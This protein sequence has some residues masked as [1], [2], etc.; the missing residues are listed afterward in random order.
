MSDDSF[1]KL[2]LSG[3][4]SV[5]QKTGIYECGS[6]YSIRAM[7]DSGFHIFCWRVWNFAQFL[8]ELSQKEERTV[9]EKLLK[10]LVKMTLF[11]L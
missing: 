8:S 7:T 11:V 3:R 1:V 2:P 6:V 5:K 4:R 10:S 9:A